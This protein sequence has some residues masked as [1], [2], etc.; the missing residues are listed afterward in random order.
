MARKDTIN[1][2]DIVDKI[3]NTDN[4]RERIKEKGEQ[5]GKEAAK[6]FTSGFESGVEKGIKSSKAKASSGVSI[7]MADFLKS[8]IDA[9]NKME[10]RVQGKGHTID[11]STLIQP[12]WSK[13]GVG[14]KNQKK[15]EQAFAN[16][17]QNL[18]SGRAILKGSKE[19]IM[20]GF[21][22]VAADY[23]MEFG[24]NVTKGN[25]KSV[26][27]QLNNLVEKSAKTLNARVAERDQ[28]RESHNAITITNKDIDD[29]LKK[30]VEELAKILVDTYDK[31]DFTNNNILKNNSD[32]KKLI[33]SLTSI[34]VKNNGKIPESVKNADEIVKYV[35][36]LYDGKIFQNI[37][38]DENYTPNA[39]TQSKYKK[40]GRQLA[41]IR[42]QIISRNEDWKNGRIT[43]EEISNEETETVVKNEEKKTKAKKQSWQEE[44]RINKEQIKAQ[45]QQQKKAREEQAKRVGDEHAA[46]RIRAKD[47]IWDKDDNG[48]YK[49]TYG[50]KQYIAAKTGNN[51]SLFGLDK[52]GNMKDLDKT[53]TSIKAMKSY[54]REY[55][56]AQKDAADI[57]K[58]N[59]EKNKRIAQQEAKDEEESV[60]AKERI[61]AKAEQNKK[62][63]EERSKKDKLLSSKSSE[64]AEL[65]AQRA[66]EN[67]RNRSI[68]R[69]EADANKKAIEA[70]KEAE[71]Q[72]NEEINKQA[73]EMYRAELERR[74][75]LSE[76][77]FDRKKDKVTDVYWGS[78][79]DSYARKE[80]RTYSIFD[81][82]DN[83]IAEGL[84]NLNDVE[85]AAQ[86]YYKDI[87]ESFK[88]N[89]KSN[90]EGFKDSIRAGLYQKP[91][92]DVVGGSQEVIDSEKQVQG[93]V[94]Q[95]AQI[96]KQAEEEKQQ[97][98]EETT[99]KISEQ[100]EVQNEQS[101]QTPDASK[102]VIKTQEEVA[103]TAK[104]TANDVAQSEQH[105]QEAIKETTEV[106]KEQAKV[107]DSA[108]QKKAKG[109]NTKT[110]EE[111]LN[112]ISE[113]ELT[114]LK[115]TL[116]SF[117]AGRD[118]TESLD[119]LANGFGIN[120]TRK[121]QLNRIIKSLIS[122]PV[123]KANESFSMRDIF[124]NYLVGNWRDPDTLL[125]S[126]FAN[127]K[128][129]QT[130]INGKQY[131]LDYSIN[132]NSNFG[133]YR[134]LLKKAS[135]KYPSLIWYDEDSEDDDLYLHPDKQQI[136]A[137][138]QSEQSKQEAVKETTE[139]IKEQ[140]KVQE[141]AT[142]K[143]TLE[144]PT[145]ELTKIEL[146]EIE[147]KEIQLKKEAEEARK[148]EEEARRQAEEET[149]RAEEIKK[150]SE[151][152]RLKAEEEKKRA[153]EEKVKAE[154]EAVRK[155][156]EEAKRQA[157][158]E[159]KRLEEE[160][161]I[162]EEEAARKAKIEAE[163]EA[164][165]ARME[166]LP[167]ENI[168]KH[169]YGESGASTTVYSP[170][171]GKTVTKNTTSEG[172]SFYG[173]QMNYQE[174]EKRAIKLTNQLA[175]V[176]ASI[177]IEES[178][179]AASS[180]TR[181]NNLNAQKDILE[182][183]LEYV[184]AIAQAEAEN[185]DEVENPGY[186]ME[187]FES[188]VADD[189]E[190][191]A[192]QLKTKT[193]KEIEAIQVSNE[194]FDTKV[195]E[196]VARKRADLSKIDSIYKSDPAYKATEDLINSFAPLDRDAFKKAELE[197][198][199]SFNNL[200]QVIAKSR[201]NLKGSNTLSTEKSAEFRLADAPK[202]IQDII[203][204]Y[205]K[206]G[207]TAE[208][209]EGKVASL[210][211][212]LSQINEKE[213]NGGWAS[214][215]DYSSTVGS[216]LNSI[217]DSKNELSSYKDQVTTIDKIQRKATSALEKY[218]KATKV[219]RAGKDVDVTF[220]KQKKDA[221]KQFEQL[222][223]IRRDYMSQA[224]IKDDGWEDEIRKLKEARESIIEEDVID[225]NKYKN[226][227]KQIKITRERERLEERAYKA[228]DQYLDLQKKVDL[229]QDTD[230]KFEEQ[231]RRRL[232]LYEK[233][234]K[235]REKLR[236]LE[237]DEDPWLDHISKYREKREENI[238][239]QV[240]E[241]N[242][243]SGLPSK[244]DEKLRVKNER[245]L[246]KAQSD[247]KKQSDQYGKN[248]ANDLK[249][250][251]E[252]ENTSIVNSFN[253]KKEQLKDALRKYYSDATGDPSILNELKKNVSNLFTEAFKI[254]N[255][256]SLTG[257]QTANLQES[258]F[259]DMSDI[260]EKKFR[261]LFSESSSN[262]DKF[263]KQLLNL[264]YASDEVNEKISSLKVSLV[265]V[266]PGSNFINA[267]DP[268]KKWNDDFEKDKRDTINKMAN[269]W[270][271]ENQTN[272]F[273][274]IKFLLGS[275]GALNGAIADINKLDKKLREG[276]ISTA[277]YESEYEKLQKKWSN[278]IAS[279][280]YNPSENRDAM[281]QWVNMQAQ[282]AAVTLKWSKDGQQLT[283]VFRNQN[284]ELV[285]VVATADQFKGTVKGVV[286]EIKPM[287]SGIEAFF[288]SIG[289]KWQEVMRYMATY[290]SLRSVWTEFQ[291]GINVVR[292]YDKALT[293]MN[294]VSDASM[295]TL[296]AFQK[297]SFGIAD[298]V[299]VT[300]SV[301][302]NSTADWLRLGES[303]AQA[304]ES[305]KASAIL[306]NVSEFQDIGSATDAL[307]SA[308]QAY[309]ELS[310]T[311]IIDKINYIGNNYS[312]ATDGLASAL[313]RSAA[314]LKTQGNN[315]DQAIAL[316]TAG[317]S[318]IQNPEMVAAGIRTISLRIA[319][320]EA[321]KNQLVEAGEDVDDFIIQTKSKTQQLIKNYTAVASNSYK[322]VDVLDDNGNLRSTYD[323]LLDIS[324]VYK[325]IQKTDKAAGT[326]RANA[327]VEALAGKVLPEFIEI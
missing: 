64:L 73:E 164:R 84:K 89:R 283:G 146:Q 142:K 74:Q 81:K 216:F 154:A 140:A 268:F 107:Q 239:K 8:M 218:L 206:L 201:A 279:F 95:S 150:K 215:E 168:V 163:K 312:I 130:Q 69:D 300:A 203:N 118:Y 123:T 326:N 147:E 52:N 32:K 125:F 57:R 321:A 161:R 41:T 278:A 5:A 243:K 187:Q 304:K 135:E 284:N 98:I 196:Y 182:R 145:S 313:Q 75:K 250:L 323:I 134:K 72:A 109:R 65:D 227:Q 48:N 213:T 266:K 276:A 306:Y 166:P 228:L 205:I 245:E 63:R 68:A 58:D 229:G 195:Q 113:N 127:S 233:L 40:A 314:V 194:R 189:T 152:E 105:K 124:E 305:A 70:T 174:L 120:K 256:P 309:Q 236:Y 291:K 170:H 82:F 143:D 44:Q 60:A 86:K 67:Q 191:F 297:E 90:I 322:G 226:E 169:S 193:D 307:V 171:L 110:T 21:H 219:I 94:E 47:I 36:D 183:Q 173:T 204:N 93:A 156:A 246:A 287:K 325:E 184:R 298:S 34:L 92:A 55:L 255:N 257:D 318:I 56:N 198:N 46:E 31:R 277:K 317:N 289:S 231:A 280:S 129:N 254:L 112:G 242:K 157:E 79:G 207:L 62:K 102:D 23:I 260:A 208:E 15:V 121:T 175:V 220:E 19:A 273:E 234:I 137:I 17:I 269:T 282:G 259:D 9:V 3:I 61:Q 210:K 99:Q 49:A 295:Y 265:G 308:S 91:N 224:G 179:S 160:R 149:R 76:I 83:K 2:N 249:Q 1:V 20:K 172:D 225:E 202:D 274:N 272:R 221:E 139:V 101:S 199:K 315:L 7:E 286:Q 18:Y 6:G 117:Y 10:Q 263:E 302:Q 155:E 35:Q 230:G 97:A 292:E 132:T 267:F 270:L 296:Q 288:D 78:D 165:K 252:K 240:E 212:T 100:A 244:A 87:Y 133:D 136:E 77:T 119:M 261:N 30:S 185:D 192:A 197:I 138:I 128:S 50:K 167:D 53:T 37:S 181:I 324:K 301:V 14:P 71:K 188:N 27:S 303:F 294:K 211:E 299:G 141:E 223:R 264:G 122:N 310:K 241:A 153:E 126:I 281:K 24:R 116:R 222:L 106:I 103:K 42:D 311:D 232:E 251:L 11:M 22:E 200:N 25:S 186:T 43:E 162:A 59:Q 262:I 177:E 248:T 190:L 253:S 96:I 115:N 54:L 88:K 285:K 39:S 16:M 247:A 111:L 114:V 176:N 159:A 4:I 290:V 258:L 158:E 293:E 180:Q 66:K 12:D 28:K 13:L 85:S 275:D 238:R 131:K 209:A 80:G 104:K 327:L 178:K 237:S 38:G 316:I 144:Q 319:G 45:Q 108:E 29:Y 148:A 217:R 271:G 33:A 214:A 51:Y 235:E 151:E 320:T 26:S